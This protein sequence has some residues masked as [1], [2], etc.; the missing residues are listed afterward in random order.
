MLSN[1]GI[2]INHIHLSFSVFWPMK[3]DSLELIASFRRE[4]I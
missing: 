1:R 2:S 4:Y 3:Y